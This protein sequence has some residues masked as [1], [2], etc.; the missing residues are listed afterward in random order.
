MVF[1]SLLAMGISTKLFYISLAGLSALISLPVSLLVS[2]ELSLK[3]FPNDMFINNIHGKY[4]TPWQSLP[5][6]TILPHNSNY[7]LHIQ[8][9]VYLNE[10]SNAVKFVW[11]LEKI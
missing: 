9:F 5:I 3:P 11:A 7:L 10:C 2:L 4:C 8:K 1:L 6:L